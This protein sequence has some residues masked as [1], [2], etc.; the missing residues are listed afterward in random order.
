MK[1]LKSNPIVPLSLLAQAIAVNQAVERASALPKIGVMA[2]QRLTIDGNSYSF[3][4]EAFARNVETLSKLVLS[5]RKERHLVVADI[6][7]L[8]AVI[9]PVFDEAERAVHGRPAMTSMAPE[10]FWGSNDWPVPKVMPGVVAVIGEMFAGKTYHI[11][12]T[13]ETIALV[14]YGEPF[15]HIDLEK[16][17]I[18]VHTFEEAITVSTVLSFCG[19][20]T[21]VD[22]LRPLVFGL[23]GNATEGG[24]SG[25][26]YSLMT[27]LNNFCV[28]L[29]TT[30]V[31][32]V[33]PMSSNSEKTAG[34]YQKIGASCAG[35]VHLASKAVVGQTFRLE[36]GRTAE[37][38]TA[39]VDKPVRSDQELTR[40]V[41]GAETTLDQSGGRI[42]ADPDIGISKAGV[43]PSEVQR[44]FPVVE[45][46]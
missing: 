43:S 10:V 14:R 44:S 26:L 1:L 7:R 40:V 22:S 25:D 42:V 34:L 8:E 39:P 11:L 12:N 29:G 19:L 4:A 27:E 24:V 17:V 9:A 41:W 6:R 20:S 28:N 31:F 45:I 33:N 38:V 21:A 36:D 35:A 13:M 3:N 30:V 46:N 16:G 32:A 15:E 23:K 2:S 5:K 37:G 18:H